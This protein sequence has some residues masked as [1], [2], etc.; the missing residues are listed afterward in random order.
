MLKKLA[1]PLLGLVLS[2]A[3]VNPPQAKAGV[4]VGLGVGPV[5]VAVGPVHPYG[6][7]YPRPYYYGPY[8][9]APGYAYPHRSY[10]GGFYGGGR[11]YP[12]GYGFRGYA[13]RPGYYG[14][15]RR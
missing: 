9:Y 15:Y 10:Y 8:A 5:G 3:L 12:R 6:Y 1:L 14:R 2:L 13:G 4:V 11:W 7:V